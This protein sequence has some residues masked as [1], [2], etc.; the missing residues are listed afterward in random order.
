M[1]IIGGNLKGIRLQPPNNLPVR[2]TTDMAKEALFNILQNRFDFETCKVLDLFAGTGSLT[3]EFASRG[4]EKILAVDQHF[5][6]IKWIKEMAEKH[7]FNTIEVR[8]ADVFKLLN[9]LIETYDIIFADP[10][11]HLATI[12]QIPVIVKQ[13]GLLAPGG[14]LVVE[15]QSNMKM[16]AQPGYLETRKY[17]NS[18]F[19]F[20]EF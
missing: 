19:S 17:G 8:K 14:L 10:P 15:H 4:S 18:S 9:Q 2:P 13:K 12:P 1:R 7:H 5:G 20:F 6:C 16:D 11:Y 3:L